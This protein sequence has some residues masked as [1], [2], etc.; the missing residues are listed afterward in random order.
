MVCVVVLLSRCQSMATCFALSGQ[1]ESRCQSMATCFPLSGQPEVSCPVQL[2]P[3]EVALG[4]PVSQPEVGC[5]VL[6]RPVEV[7]LGAPV[8]FVSGTNQ[9]G[10]GVVHVLYEVD[11]AGFE[12]CDSSRGVA[13]WEPWLTG[14]NT[15]EEEFNYTTATL[16]AGSHY[17]IVEQGNDSMAACR[18]GL[19]V[20]VSVKVNHCPITNG[21]VCSAKGLCLTQHQQTDFSCFCCGG[22][23]GQNCDQYELCSCQNGGRCLRNASEADAV[24]CA[25]RHGFRGDLCQER[26]ENL[27][28]VSDCRN[29]GTCTGN[30]THFRCAC[31]EGF[32]GSHCE[33]NVNECAPKPCVH[34]VCVDGHN[35]YTCYCSPGYHGRRCQLD[36]DECA[37]GPCENQGFCQNLQDNYACHCHPGYKG[38]NCST[39]IHA[40]SHLQPCLNGARCQEMALTYK[41]ICPAGFTGTHCEVNVNDCARQ[42]C[43]NGGTCVDQV[44]A[45]TCLCLDMHAGPNC[46]FPLDMFGPMIDIRGLREVGGMEGHEFHVRNMY[47]VSGT[48]SCAVVVVLAV[49]V[50]CY[51]R[52]RAARP[53]GSIL[54]RHH[55]HHYSRHQDEASPPVDISSVANPRLS[56]DAIWEAT[57]LNYDV[58]QLGSPGRRGSLKQLD[59]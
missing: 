27:C 46:Q 11:A 58:T 5:P 9:S 15:E 1:P 32:G 22:H 31:V 13:V 4:A 42:P 30:A 57:S 39:K 24:S 50:T 43:L 7:A 54:R 18:Q 6:L 49:L 21:H 34:G 40:C 25:C 29:N 10:W 51:C 36:Y 14:N 12:S 19:R 2:R 23:R 59:I 38:R 41:C 53:L 56:V 26:V 52:V 28:Q 33:V 37:R 35:S 55:H 44:N 47:V 3:V 45:Y 16:S 8:S 17:F 48:L 20:N